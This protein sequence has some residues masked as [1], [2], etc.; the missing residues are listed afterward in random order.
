MNF[1]YLDN[2]SE[3]KKLKQFCEDA[4]FLCNIKPNFSV[5]SARLA[6]EYIIRFIFSSLNTNF[7]YEPTTF[8][9]LT[10]PG[11]EN[12]INNVDVVN[13]MH[14]I[15]KMGNIAAHVGDMTNDDA[16]EVLRELHFVVSEFAR[17]LGL[18]NSVKEFVIP[19]I[20]DT[21][22]EFEEKQSVSVGNEVIAKYAPRMKETHFNPT[23]EEYDATNKENFIKASLRE[24]G[25]KISSASNQ[26][27][28][29][30]ACMNVKL[31][32]SDYVDYIING[33]D[34]KPLAIIEYIKPGKNLIDARKVA[35]SKAD[36]L[37][38]KYGYK[39]IVYY[40]NGYYIY[41]IDQLGYPPRR[42]FEIHS[43][44][45]M[46]L[47]KQRRVLRKDISNPTIDDNITNREYQKQAIRAVCNALGG[48]E[49]R[50][51]LI[52]MA[53][54]TGKTRV[55]I[56]LSDILLKANWV[57]NI[58]FLA[59]RTS[60]VRQAH[61]NFTKILPSVTT[62]VYTGQSLDRDPNAR[63]IFSTYQTMLSLIN[64]DT[65]E[66]GIGRFDLIIVDEA[67]RSIF[68][69]Y[70]S[71]FTYFDSLMIGLTATPKSEDNK[72]TYEV[73]GLKNNSPDFAYELKQATEDN[74]LV[75]FVVLDR[76]SEVLKRG[77]KYDDLT[78]EEK[79]DIENILSEE[80]LEKF[81]KKDL[82]FG[83][84]STRRNYVNI[85]TIDE[86][87]ADLIKNGLKVDG[88]DKLGKTIIF[89]ESHYQAEEIVRRYNKI[90]SNGINDFCKLIDSKVENSYQLIDKF[91]ERNQLP[92]IAV[93]VDMLDTGI[94]V[95]DI[96]NLVFFKQVKSKI[97]FLQMIGRG[98]RLSKDIFAPG[99]DKKGF[100]IFDYFDNFNYFN[101]HYTWN[102]DA[103]KIKGFDIPRQSNTINDL[104][105]EILKNLQLLADPN[106]FELSYR[107]ELEDELIANIN[108]LSVDDIRVQNSM[109]YINTYKNEEIL[110]NLT[111]KDVDVI[112]DKL[113]PLFSNVDGSP[114][115]KSFDILIYEIEL[116][117]RK[118]LYSVL[119]KTKSQDGE[120]TDEVKALLFNRYRNIVARINKMMGELLK[121][122]TIP[123]I[124]AKKKTINRM[125]NL[126]L[127]LNDFSYEKCENAR[128]E[129]RD[130][131]NYIPDDKSYYTIDI[132]DKLIVDDVIVVKT[133]TYQE[134]VQN[135]LAD[136]KNVIL[137]KIKNLD[138]L[139]QNDKD[140]LTK[141]FTQILG[142]QT[143]YSK[144]SNKP[145]L[146]K[147]RSQIGF[148]DNAVNTKFGSF[149]NH[150]VL[151]D[152]QYKFIENIIQYTRINGDITF[153]DLQNE[154]PFCDVDIVGMFD[155]KIVH[156]KTLIN[157][158]HNAVK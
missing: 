26:M 42:V 36:E 93:S 123:Q 84:A 69:K 96:L 90:Y 34:N 20:K 12:K 48:S 57:K 98:T 72:N 19:T 76:T 139:S 122:N 56:S 109:S 44:E 41:C 5:S 64:D 23:S 11:F 28:P 120:I 125:Y 130:L 124:V 32:N 59:D 18:T 66:F 30:C 134:K 37:E 117:Y 45:E 47:L 22:V 112:E 99:V 106:T 65:R 3:F 17:Y 87:L 108:S 43:I 102:I 77:I 58:L 25:W 152:N 6:N 156:I 29:C 13:S 127:L 119:K 107:K 15:R 40:T 70:G 155:S 52:V 146:V 157:E 49:R 24:A 158:L 94:D 153:S 100:Y 63:I 27:M 133:Q 61:K 16:I 39:P 132:Y 111:Q 60:L 2:Y 92:Q 38:K 21:S 78:E 51:S 126:E 82:D 55:A 154:S 148:T 103:Q 128:K 115:M 91:S 73:F 145:L 74:Y 88:G 137:N 147:I 114:R 80:D 149:F 8:E 118:H 141:Q 4:E 50:R 116:N 142:T 85:A 151:D 105:I 121:L 68:S 10:N 86:M 35:L 95:P 71:L 9:M 1:D 97:K 140:E 14:Y 136:D 54:G 67:H 113:I 83:N 31:D 89:A 135:Y 101:S 150:N 7:E 138:I 33:N 75:G 131:I 129:L 79:N 53:T 46:E 62:S 81:E 143:D 104:K 110:R 144:W